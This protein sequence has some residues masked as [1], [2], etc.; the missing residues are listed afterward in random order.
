MS[1]SFTT[2]NDWAWGELF[3]K[4]DI[5]NYIDAHERFEI[6]ASQI[7]E[8]R[9]PRLMAKHDQSINLPKIFCDNDLAILP[10]ARGKYL[11]SHFKAYHRFEK[12]NTSIEKAEFP[13]YL[14]SIDLSGINSEAIALNCAY[15]SGMI[16][17]FMEDERLVPT[18][19]GRM[20]SGLFEFNINNS[21][22]DK[23]CNVAVCNSQIEIDA[24]YEGLQSFS[25]IEAKRDLADDF[26]IRQLFYPFQAWRKRITKPIQPIFL[27][28][29]NG[30]FHLFGYVF[31]NPDNY[32]S[33]ILV[34]QKNYSFED[35]SIRI[36][37]IESI[38]NNVTEVGEPEIPF[39]Q[40]DNFERVINLCELVGDQ[41]LDRDDITEQYAFDARQTNYYTDAARYLGLIEK[42]RLDSSPFFSLS[43][44]G[45]QIFAMNYKERQLALCKCILSHKVFADA[46]KLHFDTGE[47]PDKKKI[48]NSMKASS[49]YNIESESTYSRRASTIKAWVNWILE[50]IQV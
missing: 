6:T 9:E 38:L 39:P 28:Y 22:T 7:K 41:G 33:L 16:S 30:I 34:K 19:S 35:I 43:E 3:H 44:M 18:V 21:K 50:I 27:V 5:L 23:L 31:E 15:I 13:S 40:A 36:T 17:D 26:L 14:Q 37:D 2:Q 47:M 4:Y 49:L 24:A 32:N 29:S 25:L 12:I 46:L 10:T 20:G 1:N 42:K 8:F 48:I 11:I 45:K